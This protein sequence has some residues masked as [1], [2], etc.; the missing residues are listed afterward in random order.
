MARLPGQA[1]A[2]STWIAQRAGFY[3]FETTRIPFSSLQGWDFDQETGNLVHQSGRFF[4]I[5]GIAVQS[6]RGP[7]PQWSQPIINQPEIGILGIL[8]RR[9]DGELHC[10]MQAKME[11]GNI[12]TVQVSPTVQ[13]TRS[14]YTRV[15][16]GSAIRYL[17][18]FVQPRHG[19]VLVDVLQSEQGSWFLHKRNRNMIVEVDEDVPVH[20]DFCWLPLRRIWEL[21]AADNIINMDART[22]LSCLPFQ[23][24]AEGPPLTGTA[25]IL[26]WFTEMKATTEVSARRMPLRAIDRWH[27]SADEIAHEDGKFFSV[28]AVSAQAASREVASWTQPL[29]APRNQG[30]VAFLVK[31]IGGVLHLLVQARVEPGYIDIIELAPTVQCDP[32]NYRDL[33]ADLRPPFLDYVLNADA[34]SI[35]Y[36]A[37]QSEEGGRF[38]HAQN[39]YVIVEAGDDLPAN[40]PP[41]FQW[42]TVR[43]ITGL[44]RHSYYVNVQARSLIACLH[45]LP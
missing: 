44:L 12:N 8:V 4:A 11:P 20:D 39:R 28:V 1:D 23:D 24:S 40:L 33:P 26:S 9:L 21:L 3:E 34:G 22:V 18:H 10:L 32:A 6:D 17:E 5:E 13:A 43:Q 36:D 29:L 14:N 16:Q 19:R 2:F 31:R 37:L 38:Y 7:V 15:H 35:K 27:R 42:L 45:S 25:S 41:D 30:V